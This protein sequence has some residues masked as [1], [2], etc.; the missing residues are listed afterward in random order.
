M[1]YLCAMLQLERVIYEF[2][3]FKFCGIP[4]VEHFL[5]I[6]EALLQIYLADTSR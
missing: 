1:E 6:V 4:D 5:V 3:C 2:L